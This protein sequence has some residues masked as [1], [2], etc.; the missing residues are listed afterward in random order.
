MEQINYDTI[1]AR[2]NAIE[3]RLKDIEEGGSGKKEKKP[4]RIVK[5]KDPNAPKRPPNWF[6]LMKQDIWKEVD[7][8]GL[9]K[10][11]G[12]KKK[13]NLLAT[14]KEDKKA[15]EKYEKEAE[16]LKEIHNKEKEKYEKNKAKI[17]ADKDDSDNEDLKTVKN[18]ASKKSVKEK[19]K[20]NSTDSDTSTSK[21]NK[22]SKKK[23]NSTDSDS[24]VKDEINKK[25]NED[26][27]KINA[28]ANSPS[29]ES[30]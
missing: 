9:S 20:S 11:E 22:T 24:D 14:R 1:I 23:S 16:K 13:M 7:K 10:D 15:K 30:D 21:K 25:R 26:I 17:L 5:P 28:L 8:E 18:N 6:F 12:V 3:A 29:D 19:K 2:L 4:K 27:A